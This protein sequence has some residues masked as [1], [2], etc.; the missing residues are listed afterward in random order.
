MRKSIYIVEDNKDI[1]YI[2]QYFLSEEG[3]DA[4]LFETV[5]AFK[6][7]LSRKVPDLFLLDVMLPD[8]DGIDVCS[9]I[10]HDQLLMRKPVI[11][12]SAHFPTEEAKQ[13]SCAD[14]FIPKPF[15]LFSILD[16]VRTHLP[17]A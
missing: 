1:G 13:M 4:E 10:K 2:L 14:D 17:A 5:A 16:R 6:Q 15:D 11:I 12:M 3:F 9:G 7:G 8:G